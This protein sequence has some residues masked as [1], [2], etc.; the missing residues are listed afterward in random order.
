MRRTR[1]NK[2][3]T[4][5]ELLMASGISVGVLFTAVMLFIYGMAQWSRGESFII[6]E[7]GSQVAVRSIANELREAMSVTVDGNGLGLSYRL[8]KKVEDG[9]WKSP[10]E[11]DGV[12]RRIEYANGSIRVSGGET[13]RTICANVI[14]TDPEYEGNQAYK[15]FTA[16]TGAITRQ[17]MVMV[18]T[19]TNEYRQEHMT[20]RSRETIYLRNVPELLGN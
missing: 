9:S 6:A 17:L 14:L 13:V 18:V 20:S 10:V 15:V 8:P 11:W 12:D 16:G 4:T 3:V 5:V 7:S 1:R 19:K 2:G